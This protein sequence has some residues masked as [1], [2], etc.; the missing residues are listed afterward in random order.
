MGGEDMTE[1]YRTTWITDSDLNDALLALEVAQNRLDTADKNE[2]IDAAI[3][4]LSAAEL[5]I[6]AVIS[7]ARGNEKDRTSVTDD[8]TIN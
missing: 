4:E 7:R 1:D 6:R 8:F 3:F 5:R 2:L